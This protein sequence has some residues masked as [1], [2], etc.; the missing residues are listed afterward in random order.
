MAVPQGL[1]YFPGI[2]Q[3]ISARYTLSHGITPG[4]CSME[5]A[6]QADITA[7]GGPLQF[8]FGSVLLVF[9]DCRVDKFSYRTNGSGQVIGLNIYDRRWKWSCGY[10]RGTFNQVKPDDQN[11]IPPIDQ[12]QRKNA[13][14]LAKLI[15]DDG[16]AETNYDISAIP[17]TIYPPIEW[18]YTNPAQALADLAEQCGCRVVLKL[19]NAIQLAK[20]GVGKD[21]PNKDR[22]EE[23]DGIDPPEVPDSLMVVCGKTLFQEDFELEA[24]GLDT[25]GKVKLLND[26]SYKPAA[27]WARIDNSTFNTLSSTVPGVAVGGLP[28]RPGT[29]QPGSPRDLAKRTVWRWYRVKCSTTAPLTVNG[30]DGGDIKYLDRILPLEDKQVQ[31]VTRN[32]KT[33]R[34]EAQ[35]Y[36]NH[37]TRDGLWENN[38]VGTQFKKPFTIL[39]DKGIVEFSEPCYRWNGTAADRYKTVATMW[40]R[41]AFNIK[42]SDTNAP[43]RY[44]K[45]L[46]VPGAKWDTGPKI[47]LHDEIV[48]TVK[49][50]YNTSGN[51]TSIEY[52]W[53]DILKEIDYA[54][55]AALFQ[56]QTTS[57]REVGYAGLVRIDPDGC[58]Q[59]VSW[60]V[61]M[62]GATTRASLNTEF[63]S[64][65]PTYEVRRI[66]ESLR[67]QDLRRAP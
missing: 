52:N 4:V 13:R 48:Q 5:I 38:P 57:Q 58:I 45:E 44:V 18:D 10:M 66:W 40:L 31:K 3:I 23:S 64:V 12:E 63:S 28:V 16:M 33:V 53:D 43:V 39:G 65:V 22:M 59:Q 54:L 7:A 20:V 29:I 30:Y 56:Y 60:S 50:V 46:E 15:L 55:K 36:G 41:T 6:P 19:N 51:L 11:A 17:D 61:G 37:G 8:K 9:P 34:L 1:A 32:D 47:L 27:G 2:K 21:L 67:N 25:D 26:L 49:P 14:A 42:D 24:V 62:S 35:V